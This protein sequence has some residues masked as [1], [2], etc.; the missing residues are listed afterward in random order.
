MRRRR[1]QTVVAALLAT[2]LVP[3]ALGQDLLRVS[4]V[5][6]RALTPQERA[7]VQQARVVE[8]REAGTYGIIVDIQGVNEST[9]GTTG[10]ASLGAAFAEASYFDRALQPGNSYSA[11][12]QLG[13]TLLGAL[14]GSALDTRPVPRFHFRYAVKL[15]DGEIRMVDSV[16][17]DAFRLPTGMC[18]S[19]PDLAQ[20]GQS[21]CTQSADDLRRLYVGARDAAPAVWLPTAPPTKSEVAPASLPAGRV[22]CR[23]GSL[24]AVQTTPEK[25]SSIGGEMP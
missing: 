12:T 20:I 11:K 15:A 21:V 19:L 3:A 23:L 7:A 22:S 2:V 6:W 25:C 24:P 14:A 5:A 10:G 1:L 17:A 8:I 9:P 13:V 18:V 4:A 16:Q